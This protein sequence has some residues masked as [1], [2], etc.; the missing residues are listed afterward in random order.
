MSER[1]G[2]RVHFRDD[3]DNVT[4]ADYWGATYKREDDGTLTIGAPLWT[5]AVF[6]RG[7]WRY[8]ERL[9]PDTEEATD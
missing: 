1:L 7:V 4:S 6:A 8:V 9:E 5:L 2:V 3:W